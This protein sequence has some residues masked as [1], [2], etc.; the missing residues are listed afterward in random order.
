[1][2]NYAGI[3][4]QFFKKLNQ[5]LVKFLPISHV[6][7]NLIGIIMF[8]FLPWVS[9]VILSINLIVFIVLEYVFRKTYKQVSSLK[10]I[11]Y[12]IQKTGSEIE[13][14]LI[15]M[16]N[17]NFVLE[18]KSSA[19]ESLPDDAKEMLRLGFDTGERMKS[20]INQLNDLSISLGR[21]SNRMLH[22]TGEQA[23]AS[24]EQ[25]ASVAE[26]TA[27]M[28]ELAKTAAQIANNSDD[29]AK[30]ASQTE[31]S[32]GDG[33]NAVQDTIGNIHQ[34]KSKIDVIQTNA[35]DLG[36]KSGEINKI[37]NLITE[38]ANETH[39]LA[40]NASIES[41]AAGEYGKRFGVVAMEVRRLAERSSES[42]ENIKQLLEHFQ[43]SINSTI[44]STEEGVKA[45]SQT[46]SS[47]G[48][49]VERFAEIQE[50]VEQTNTAS[51]EISVA[52]Q[53]QR[54]ASEQ[55]V[56]TLKEISEVSN[57]A[58]ENLNASTA[59]AEDLTTHAKNV[60]LF[61]QTFTV[62][63][64]N[65]I[66]YMISSFLSGEYQDCSDSDRDLIIRTFLDRHPFLEA[67][68][69]T[70]PDGRLTHLQTH[71]DFEIDTS[72]FFSKSYTGKLWHRKVLE[73]GS[74]WI[75]DPYISELSSEEC[76]TVA[77]P[78]MEGN[79]VIEVLAVDINMKQWNEIG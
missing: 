67:M 50:L 42:A 60:Q 27:T 70:A 11:I 35:R 51:K 2:R 54:T 7:L 37:L 43:D 53:Q 30:V 21:V 41:V 23:S 13:K 5:P 71:R 15:Q 45:V 9:L 52:T 75:T 17:R 72:S 38:I 47:A 79:E 33:F 76:F 74:S 28:E 55:I 16:G 48:T 39:L 8:F 1:M 57:Q 14:L 77:A 31:L 63:K 44:L 3:F 49:A 68:F 26:I 22:S 24:S 36:E 10:F 32:S 59:A 69:A 18:K 61:T 65:N 19:L 4:D 6:V 62:A 73:K 40:L 34:L 64:S 46:I 25:A 20:V 29:V 58:A 66:K 78:V 12:G 56:L